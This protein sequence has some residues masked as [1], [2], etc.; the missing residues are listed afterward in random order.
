MLKT[1][2]S[3][4][5][6]GPTLVRYEALLANVPSLGALRETRQP[7]VV[8]D[9]EE[10][11]QAASAHSD[12]LKSRQY[13]SS[14]TLPVFRGDELSAFLF[15]DSTQRAAFAPRSSAA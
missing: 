10:R 5:Q 4:N 11:F 8:D 7:R 1:F 3:S 12:W 13:R 2:T 14:Y 6:G 15:F 9:I